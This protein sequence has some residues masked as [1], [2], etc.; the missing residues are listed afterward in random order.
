MDQDIGAVAAA[1]SFVDTGAS[2]TITGSG[3]DIWGTADEF[4][5]A[6]R[7]LNGDGE[8]VA[9]VTNLTAG[10]MWSKVGLM[11]RETVA[12]NS[13][14]GTMFLGALKG[15]AFQY[16][17][18]NGGS[19]AGDNG[20]SITTLPRWIRVQRQGNVIRGYFSSD[21]V[22]WTQRGTVTLASLPTSV[23]IGVAYTSHVDGTIG[24]ATL[25]NVTL[26]GSDP[27]PDT[28]PPS[29]P[30]N[31]QATAISTSR[32]DLTWTASTDTGGSGLS[33]LSRLPQWRRD[34]DRDRRDD[35]L[36]ATRGLA[37]G[38]QLTYTVRAVGRREQCV[39]RLGL[40]IG[41]DA[42]HAAAGY[43][44]AERAGQPAGDCSQRHRA[45][46]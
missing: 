40:C 24:S 38:T 6:Y 12:A 13:R 17:T 28:T 22:N 23:L 26:T 18:N 30:T 31:L 29:V 42:D 21:G 7:P 44:C 46:I 2:M 4:H 41:D 20:D 3:A 36:L 35:E 33:G 15:A 9:R 8:L 5:F 39:S 37:S 19:S 16:R 34:A 10:H 32:I 1:G 45:L 27:T 25:D 14:H 11:V 43:D